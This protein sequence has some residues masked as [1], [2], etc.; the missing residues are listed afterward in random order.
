MSR[1][2]QAPFA[3]VAALFSSSLCAQSAS[4][5]AVR[6]WSLTDVTRVVVEATGEFDF[7][8]DRAHSP[9]RLYFDLQDT[10]PA[11]VKRGQQV[12]PVGDRL[13]KQVRV[14]LTQPHVTRVVFDLESEVE[15]S[16][17]Q[18]SNPDRLIVEL[19]PAGPT[20][21]LL[22][23]S[24]HA[25]NRELGAARVLAA[26]GMP[27]P[28]VLHTRPAPSFAEPPLLAAAHTRSP[29]LP[30]L[31]AAAVTR[32]PLKVEDL[33]DLTRAKERASAALAAP[34]PAKLA[35]NRESLA[36]VLGLKVGR[37]VIDAGHGG[38][39][40]GTIGR[41]GLMEK[42]LVLDIAMRLGQLIESRLASEVIHTRPEDIFVPLEQRTAIANQKKADLFLSIHANSSPL[43]S[44]SGVETYYLNF[45]T[46]K[47]AMEVAA[48]ENASSQGTLFELKNLLQKIALNDKI[49]ESR[50][51]AEKVQAALHSVTVKS[52]SR[53]KNRGV[54]KAP[55]VV[56]IGAS[57]PSVL[58]EIG[59]VSN[60]RDE[61]LL[62]RPEY[63]QKLA[64]A[65][66]KGLS[67]YASTLSHFQ[68]A[69][70]RAAP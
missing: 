68:V 35:R 25:A 13:L 8:S 58:C 49:E 10:R 64:E 60:A 36:R 31:P 20:T 47:S 27:E 38:S 12:V 5:T 52:N 55:F 50:E 21:P 46:S 62:K 56:L 37:I 1:L 61:S 57:M 53:S 24:S 17:S 7:V 4:V 69:G 22:E 11:F 42:D 26:P 44:S 66:F 6:F 32:E 19:R 30:P 23:L 9:E 59:F 54:K 14:A 39:D 29:V 40:T 41:D 45:T 67:Q 65:L 43:R 28:P 15:F 70:R 18:L 3:V 34:K 48:R 16:A 33:P 63:R 51:F 2:S